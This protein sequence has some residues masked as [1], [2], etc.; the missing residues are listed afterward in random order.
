MRVLFAVNPEKSIFQ[1]LVPM[2]W[3][4]RTAGHEVHVAGRPAFAKIVMQAGLTA[5]PIGHDRDNWR[6][7]K[8]AP[9]A[10]AKVRAGIPAPYD[11]FDDPAKQT[12]D[13]L[14]PGLAQAVS[15]WH[16][17]SNF[18]MIAA[19]VDYARYWKPDLVIWEPMTFAGSIAAKACGAAHARLLFGLDVFGGVRQ[20]FLDLHRQQPPDHATDPLMTWFDGYARRYGF[21]LTEDL[22]TGHFTIDQFP[23]TLQTEAPGL[24][25][26]RMQ[27]IPYGGPATIPEWLTKPPTRPRVAL[28]MGLSA[29]E[30]YDGYTLDI[31]DLIHT[32]A[33]LDIELVATI[34]EHEQ[35][36]LGTLPPNVRVVPYVPWHALAPT[37]AAVIHH[38]GAATLATTSRHP[39]PQL[40]LHYHFDQPQLAHKLATHGAGLQI[41]TSNAT[42]PTVR[43]AVH[44]LLTEPHFHT[45]ATDLAHE[46][47]TLPSPN[48]IVPHLETLTAH[49]HT[50]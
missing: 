46:I 10:H 14:A 34:A 33:E 5:V 7:A 41:H 16:R 29:T 4:L 40:A 11:A 2:A 42:G 12:W 39:V 50:P 38:A 23:A 45:R 19:L 22:A 15:G 47:T 20:T 3:A 49:H 44:R 17:G 48:Q 37:C 25:Y 35:P 43:D 32:L 28:T 26:L 27:Y 18:P 8:M 1:Y 21:D 9:D 36:A 30:I 31:G 6:V 24:H 13:Y